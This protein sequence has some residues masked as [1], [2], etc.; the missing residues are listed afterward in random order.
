MTACAPKLRADLADQ[1][2]TR[3]RRRVDADLVRAR[4]EDGRCVVRRAH[5]A[6]DGEGNE[7][8]RRRAPHRIEQ[9]AAALVRRRNVEQHNLVRALR[10][11]AMRQLGRVARVDDIDKLHA[12]HDAAAAHIQTGDNS[13]GQQLFLTCACIRS[14]VLRFNPWPVFC[15]TTRQ[16]F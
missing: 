8:L 13:L 3:N 16:S 15:F 1:L 11:M 2:R 7:E 12:L 14:A 6:A 9:R 5:A 4:V 10:R